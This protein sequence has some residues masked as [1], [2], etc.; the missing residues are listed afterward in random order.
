MY[1]FAATVALCAV[2]R[3]VFQNVDTSGGLC[4][5]S[6]CEM[7]EHAESRYILEQTI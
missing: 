5:V 4:V 1:A 7:T 6:P 2:Q 3:F